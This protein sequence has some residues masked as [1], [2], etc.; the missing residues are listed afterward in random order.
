MSKLAVVDDARTLLAF[1]TAVHGDLKSATNKT[2]EKLVGS[3]IK[4]I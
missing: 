2:K 4:S 3:C 1:R